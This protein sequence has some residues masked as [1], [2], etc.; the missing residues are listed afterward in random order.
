MKRMRSIYSVG[1]LILLAAATACTTQKECSG[2]GCT[3]DEAT[4]AAVNAAIAAHADL[5]PPGQI[6]V[7]TIDHVVY[8]T[9][10]VDSGYERSI[11]ESLA[12]RTNGVT[13]VVDSIGLSK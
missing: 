2:T 10:I 3:P 1:T 13:R 12:A 11:A 4:T 7:S 8:L 9:G 6:Q 5:G